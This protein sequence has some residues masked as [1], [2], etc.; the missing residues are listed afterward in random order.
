GVLGAGVLGCWVLGCWGATCWVQETD[1]RHATFVIAALFAAAVPVHGQEVRTFTFDTAL[2]VPLEVQPLKGA[3]YSADVITESVQ[4]LADGNRIVHRS[5]G[6]VYRDS[7]GRV[8]R[9]E[10]RASGAPSVSII[11]PVAGV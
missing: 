1:M 11:D 10:D 4:S 2:K 9:E 6:R 7:E 8:R 5:T 3:P